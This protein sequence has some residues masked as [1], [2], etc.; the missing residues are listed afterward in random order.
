MGAA[1]R[2]TVVRPGFHRLA[3]GFQG[4]AIEQRMCVCVSFIL[5]DL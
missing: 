2:D 3:Q 4:L 1:A 5:D